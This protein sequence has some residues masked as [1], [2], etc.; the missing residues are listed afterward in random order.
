MQ[1]FPAPQTVPFALGTATSVQ[2]GLPL[3]QSIAAFMHGLVEGQ[4]A[5]AAAGQAAQLPARQAWFARQ[6]TATPVSTQVGVPLQSRV[7]TS[8]LWPA[9]V[10]GAPCTQALHEPPTQTLPAVPPQAV[11]SG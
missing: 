8:Q 4:G 2:T 11:A 9:G 1:V 5:S 10:H 3:V 7:P 6:V